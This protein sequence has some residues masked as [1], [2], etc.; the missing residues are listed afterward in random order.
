MGAWAPFLALLIAAV[1]THFNRSCMIAAFV[2][3][4]VALIVHMMAGVPLTV[5]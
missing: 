4:F 3:F 5:A 1:A 2:L